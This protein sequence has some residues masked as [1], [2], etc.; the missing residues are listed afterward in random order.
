LHKTVFTIASIVLISLVI[1]V[2]SGAQSNQEARD[3]QL[4]DIHGKNFSL[5]DFKGKIILLEF[6]ASWCGP[7]KPQL[8]ELKAIRAAYPQ[9]QLAMVS[10]SFDP[11]T[12]TDEILSRLADNV[13]A[14]WIL[15]RDTTGISDTYEV[16]IAPTIFLV[17]RTGFIR[18]THTGFTKSKILAPE[19]DQLISESP[20]PITP[21]SPSGGDMTSLLLVVVII[22]MA[23]SAVLAIRKRRPRQKARRPKR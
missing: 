18:Y 21:K 16:N 4:T 19:I 12:D 13:S 2:V 11:A 5:Y 3:F 22:I 15:A 20:P 17:D 9:E 1:S 14:T 10:I 8:T 7:C 23:G 6:F